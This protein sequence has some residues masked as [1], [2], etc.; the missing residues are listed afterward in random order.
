MVKSRP[1]P[2]H[3]PAKP[4]HSCYSRGCREPACVEA[5]RLYERDAKRRRNRPDGG[6]YRRTLID[7]TEVRE[8]LYF[9]MMHGVRD[10]DIARVAGVSKQWCVKVR[11]GWGRQVDAD[12]ARRVLAIGL[13]MVPKRKPWRAEQR[14]EQLRKSS[15]RRLR[16]AARNRAER[17]AKRSKNP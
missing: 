9:L 12:K 2:K 14:L 16:R 1:K 11:G 10:E 6:V 8:H 3:D 15:R 4:S 13:H 17:Q 7:A 5:H